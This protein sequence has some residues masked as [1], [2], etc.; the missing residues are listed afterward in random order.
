MLLATVSATPSAWM[1][2]PFV[3]MLL[4]IAVMPFVAKGHWERSYHRWSVALG[5][6]SIGYYLLVLHNSERVV[7]TGHEY[8]SFLS[9]IGSLFTV[10]GGIHIMVKGEAK[11]WANVLYLLIAAGA[12]NLIG[13]TGASMLLVRPWIRMNKYRITGFHI[14]FFIFIVS[15]VAGCLTPIG[16]PPLFLG[17]LKGVPFWWVMQHCWAAWGIA[18]GLLLA[19]FFVLDTWNFQRAPR[20]VRERETHE[21]KWRFGGGLNLVFLA[22]IL[23]SVFINNPPFLREAIMVAAALASYFTTAKEVHNAN[24][25]SLAPLKEVAWLFFGIF[26]TMMP[27]LDLLQARASVLGLE[28]EMHFYWGAGALSG[29][30]DNAPTYLAFLAAAFGS[31]GLP[32]ESGM[33]EFLA[34]HGSYLIAISVGAV[35]F[36]AMTYIGNGPNFMVK[37]IADQ[38][39]V[40]T[41]GFFRYIVCYSAPILL[42][43]LFI[44]GMLF[45][46]RWRIF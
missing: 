42:P 33:H 27:A 11:P 28:T 38:A 31:A 45:F 25:F 39:K 22:V 13:T 29:V 36:G 41:P 35:F 43:V 26:A 32:I 17:Y 1:V 10:A 8:L 19:V 2:L 24:D 5:V 34:S 21:E 15:N 4:A 46:S 20:Q 37:A 16:D 6:L 12:A 30:L 3:A 7:H 40:E 23:G 14:V 9:L 18:I 44:V